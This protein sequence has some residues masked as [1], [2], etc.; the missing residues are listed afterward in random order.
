MFPGLPAGLSASLPRREPSLSAVG[1]EAYFGGGSQPPVLTGVVLGSHLPPLLGRLGCRRS[2]DVRVLVLLPA[3][4]VGATSE[5]CDPLWSPWAPCA[6]GSLCR[7]LRT[8][9]GA[10]PRPGGPPEPWACGGRLQQSELVPCSC[11]LLPAPACSSAHKHL[12]ALAEPSPAPAPPQLSLVL[13]W[14]LTLLFSF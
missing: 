10:P 7:R 1:L 11:L 13:F 4:A 8:G 3:A 5:C 12:P 2:R 6:T 9:A 14:G